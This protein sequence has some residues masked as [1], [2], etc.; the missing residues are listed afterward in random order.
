MFGVVIH[1]NIISMALRGEYINIMNPYWNYA[2]LIFVSFLSVF[3]FSFFFEKLG[4]WFDAITLIFQVG[5][6]FLLLSVTI[7]A[8]HWYR[9]KVNI[10]A[11]VVVVALAGLFV[12]IYFGL[13]KKLLAKFTFSKKNKEKL[14]EK[15]HETH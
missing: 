2:L 6:S 5:I 14:N 10:T 3:L 15:E 9:I 11:A 1:A 7:Y 8:F 13:I 4:F 12:E